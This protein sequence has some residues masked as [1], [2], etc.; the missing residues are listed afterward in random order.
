ME[1]QKGTMSDLK[2]LIKVMQEQMSLQARQMEALIARLGPAPVAP[3]ASAPSFAPFDPTSE[4]WKD[5]RDRFNTFAGANSIP[6]GKIAQVFLTNQSATTYKLL[7]TLAGQ[8][9][10]P[11]EINLL[12][13]EEIQGFMDQQFDP[14]RFVVRGRFKFWSDMKRLPGEMIQELGARIRQDAATCNFTSIKD[15]QDEALRTRFI[16]SV[17]NEA[18]LKALFKINDE[19]LTFARAMDLVAE[20]EEAAKVAKETVYG[21]KATDTSSS[22]Y[23]VKPSKVSPRQKTG[24]STF[25]FPKGTC[26]RCGR[27]DHFAKDCQFIDT[28]C[29]YC[30]KKEHLEA[31]CMKKKGR[32]G[33]ITE[34]P[35]KIIKN[36][37][38]N[39]PV[40]QKLKLNGKFFTFEV[41]SGTKDNFCSKH[42]WNRLGKP[43]LRPA[44]TRYVSA[45][46]D[47]VPVLGTFSA[48]ACLDDS[49]QVKHI[50]LNVSPLAH[51]NLLG[52]TAI[53]DLGIDVCAL[54]RE[55]GKDT[56]S[57]DVHSILKVGK[58][59]PTLLKACQ[60]LCAGFPDLFKSE[61]GCLKDYELEIAFK[62]GAKP[63]FCKPRTVP[64]AIL[65]DL[66]MAYDAGIRKGVWKS[67][68]FNDYGT[69]VVPIRKALLPGQKK[70]KLRI[71]GDY[72]VTVNPHLEIHRH[73]I[74]RPEDLMQKLGGRFYFS[75]IDLADAYNQVKLAP[76]SQ[77]RLALSTHQGILLQTRLPFG[78][79][80]APGYFQRIMDQLTS[81]LKGVAV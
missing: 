54:L 55:P 20:M 41:D 60:Q 61:L 35:V 47:G 53:H 36:I 49:I 56:Y 22:V 80:S 15:A 57:D 18:I 73:P 40:K 63:V 52:R 51:L 45:T 72:S 65:G 78:I 5:Y 74:P 24:K 3:V 28:T 67:V 16:C 44:H 66:N 25:P 17:G 10:P 7:S 39:D 13:M 77:K 29:H 46:G 50:M 4:L 69:P 34:K 76:E 64:Y 12:T 26:L 19:E 21:P 70:A 48:K 42:I 43:K 8:Q 79:S 14:R 62:P 27:T 9:T 30:I 23:K 75:K 38:G 6:E 71:C 37:P 2:D 59:E 81:D 68:Q 33:Y 58:F 31:V 11:Q 32:I 1:V